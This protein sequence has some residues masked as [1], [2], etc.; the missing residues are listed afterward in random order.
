MDDIVGI[1]KTIL[2]LTAL[3]DPLGAIPVFL[4]V[5]AHQGPAKQRLT[6]RRAAFWAFFIL[7][8]SAFAGKWILEIFGVS[9][10]SMR[11]AGGILFLF[12]GIE[13]LRAEPNR[14]IN[15][16]ER[17][18]AESHSDVA[19]VP[20]ALPILAGPGAM[21]AVILL[22]DHG[23]MWPQVPKVGIMVGVVMFITWICLHLAAPI[24]KKLGVTGLNVLNRVMGL[25]VVAIAVEFIVLGVKQ[26]WAGP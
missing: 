6:A 13:M 11:V 3:V 17:E 25:I 19:V 14:T 4:T 1:L 20:L 24:G 10:S 5:T 22:A 18:E 7:A 23:P 8:V 26:L 15:D 12:M 21:G 2:S 16:E 9:I